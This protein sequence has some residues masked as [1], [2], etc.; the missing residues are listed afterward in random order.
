MYRKS[1]VSALMRDAEVKSGLSFVMNFET[2]GGFSIILGIV[3]MI[4]GGLWIGGYIILYDQ[5]FEFTPNYLNRVVHN[6]E[7]NF[8]VYYNTISSVTTQFGL[9]TKIIRID[10]DDKYQLLRCYGAVD[11]VKRLNEYISAS[12]A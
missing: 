11:F 8:I 1:Q 9:F 3:R 6:K 5:Y 12:K 7:E 10:L 2:L 4:Y